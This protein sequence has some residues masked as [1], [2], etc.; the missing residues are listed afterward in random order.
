MDLSLN[1][2]EEFNKIN[3]F[4]Y[5]NNDVHQ[6]GS[7]SPTDLKKFA[8]HKRRLRMQKQEIEKNIFE[9]IVRG[10]TQVSYF[11]IS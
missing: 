10:Q 2:L 9:A 6:P 4:Y 3:Y 5:K 7:I 1:N 11:L 8:E